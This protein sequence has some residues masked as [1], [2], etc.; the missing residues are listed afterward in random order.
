MTNFLL[1]AIFLLLA[2][3]M[4]IEAW[5]A[6]KDTRCGYAAPSGVENVISLAVNEKEDIMKYIRE[7]NQ[8]GYELVQIIPNIKAN[9]EFC[10]MLVFAKKKIKTYYE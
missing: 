5:V 10:T 1:G 2:A 4:L 7:H 8:A 9:N 6:N 3:K